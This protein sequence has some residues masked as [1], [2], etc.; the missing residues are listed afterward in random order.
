MTAGSVGS[1]KSLGLGLLLSALAAVGAAA[2]LAGPGQLVKAGGFA[3]AMV[4]ALL[5]VSGIQLFD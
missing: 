2:M 1:D 5:A 3:L 4:A